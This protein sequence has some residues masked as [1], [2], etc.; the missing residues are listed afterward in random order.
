[1]SGISNNIMI[2]HA[3]TA[4]I[5]GSHRAGGSDVLTPQVGLVQEKM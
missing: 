4:P 1:M 3:A 2:R 5:V